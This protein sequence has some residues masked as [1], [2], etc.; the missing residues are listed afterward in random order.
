MPIDSRT[1]RH[2]IVLDILDFSC[3]YDE[4]TKIL[5]VD[6]TYAHGAGELRTNKHAFKRSHW[7]LYS[8]ADD[9]YSDFDE[10]VQN[11]LFLL[12]AKSD[13]IA[14]VQRVANVEIAILGHF[15][16]ESKP[17]VHFDLRFPNFLSENRLPV[18][19]EFGIWN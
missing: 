6:P 1:F 12:G 9:Y 17:A 13:S 15:K 16:G 5:G 10:Y 18:E 7:E 3:Q 11:F 14:E 4:I 19:I 8:H 2:K